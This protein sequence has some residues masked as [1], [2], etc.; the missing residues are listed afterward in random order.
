MTAALM[1]DV[2]VVRLADLMVASMVVRKD[3]PRV[4]SLVLK[5]AELTVVVTV[6]QKAV[7]SVDLMDVKMVAQRVA[8]LAASMVDC[9]VGWTAGPK[10][11]LR[12]GCW[13]VPTVVMKAVQKVDLKVDNLVDTMAVAKVVQK[14]VNWGDLKV[15]SKESLK[16]AWWAC[17]T[18]EWLVVLT[19]AMKAGSWAGSKVV[20]TA[21][22]KAELSAAY[23][24]CWKAESRAD[25]KEHSRVESW[26]L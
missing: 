12:A 6:F 15:D 3:Q 21:V 14:V 7:N 4:A 1:A 10:D 22:W 9:W 24:V 5:T 25:K 20:R 23:L 19:V 8:S 17:L 18:A 26:V 13:A 2:W 11:L 16:A